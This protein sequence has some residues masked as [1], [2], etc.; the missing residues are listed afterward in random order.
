MQPATS[1]SKAGIWSAPAASDPG[2]LPSSYSVTKRPKVT[3]TLLLGHKET[4][5]HLHLRKTEHWY[6]R[7]WTPHALAPV[8]QQG[9]AKMG[10]S[11]ARACKEKS[12]CPKEILCIPTLYIHYRLPKGSPQVHSQVT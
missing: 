10:P 8:E 6:H 7:Q 1:G 5:S 9:K 11:P 12:S 3:F 2:K 4:N